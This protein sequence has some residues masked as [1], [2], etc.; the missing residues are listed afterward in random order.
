MVQRQNANLPIAGYFESSTQKVQYKTLQVV[1]Y[2]F[3]ATYNELSAL[4]KN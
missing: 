1:Y 4:N 2:N 3:M